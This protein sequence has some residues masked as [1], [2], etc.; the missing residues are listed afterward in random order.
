[1]NHTSFL[2]EALNDL[3][4]INKD[5]VVGYLQAANE[6]DKTDSFLKEMCLQNVREGKKNIQELSNEIN[7]LNN[8]FPQTDNNNGKVI[9]LWNEV[10]EVDGYNNSEPSFATCVCSEDAIQQVYEDTLLTYTFMPADLRTI[11]MQ[12]KKKIGYAKKGIMNYL[13][14]NKVIAVA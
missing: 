8:E 10:I 6:M 5:R 2:I 9:K 13:N 14:A 1:M 4:E 12:Q 3:I 11:M 7:K